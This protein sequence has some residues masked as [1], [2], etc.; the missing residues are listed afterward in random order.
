M[1]LKANLFCLQRVAWA[2]CWLATKLEETPR[3]IRDLLSVFV[4]IDKRR[5]GKPLTPL[6]IYSKVGLGSHAS[7]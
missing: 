5:E 1:S 3:R 6:D 4:R 2:C 7:L